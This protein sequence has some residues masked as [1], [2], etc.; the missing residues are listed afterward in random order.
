MIP[1]A[2]HSGSVTAMSM[3]AIALVRVPFAKVKETLNE[4]QAPAEAQAPPDAVWVEGG[5]GAVAIAPLD[6]A[7]LLYTG[8]SLREAEPEQLGALTRVSLGELGDEHDDERGVLFFPARAR[9]KGATTYDAVVEEAADLGDWVPLPEASELAAEAMPAGLEAMMGQVM[10]A[11][12]GDPS[13]M[14]GLWEQAQKMMTDPA[15]QAQLMSTA[16]Q[17]MAQM[18]TGEGGMDLSKMAT[19]AQEMLAEDPDLMQ[20]LAGQVEASPEGAEGAEGAAHEEDQD[21]DEG[22]S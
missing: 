2:A 11:M 8:V 6:D 1:I 18:Q 14:G 4:A 20:R 19:Q 3:E 9:P 21:E 12:G 13:Q 16:Q 7:T 5:A 10:G 17:M 15:M 22:G